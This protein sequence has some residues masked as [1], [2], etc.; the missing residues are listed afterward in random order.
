MDA[1]S[2]DGV[3]QKAT[4][5]SYWRTRTP[6]ENCPWRVYSCHKS[7]GAPAALVCAGWLYDQRRR[8]VPSLALRL[9]FY[10]SPEAVEAIK[11]VRLG[12]VKVYASLRAM[13]RANGLRGAASPPPHRR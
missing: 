2:R 8:D 3:D 13:C 12:G 10:Q 6:C 7:P 1:V 11:A 4:E 5:P 9:A